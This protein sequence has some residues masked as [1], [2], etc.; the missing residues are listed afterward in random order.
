MASLAEKQRFDSTV[1]PALASDDDRVGRLVRVAV[2]SDDVGDFLRH[3]WSTLNRPI[4]VVDQHGSP[5]ACAPTTECGY[6]ALTVGR[7]LTPSAPDPVPAGWCVLALKSGTELRGFFVVRGDPILN[8]REQGLVGVACSLLADQLCRRALNAGLIEERR[9]VLKRRLVADPRLTRERARAE[10]ARAQ[11]PIADHYWP[12][13]VCGRPA[14]MGAQLLTHIEGLLHRQAPEHVAIAYGK[15]TVIVLV[16]QDSAGA[17]N[18]VG[19]QFLVEQVI[20]SARAHLH[21]SSL[22]GVIGPESA[23]LTELALRVGDLRRLSRS[24]DRPPAATERHVISSTSFALH[25]LLEGV[26]RKRAMEFV[27]GQIG[28]LLVYDRTHGAH[29]A[30]ILE[31]ALDTHNREDAARAAYMHRNTFRRHFT[32]ANELVQRDLAEPGQRLAVHVALKLA[33][34]LGLR[35]APEEPSP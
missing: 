1:S 9:N 22:R 21:A 8:E 11:M 18:A 28:P 15:G 24:L 14:E 4:A 20:D 2:D 17:Q 31:I 12:A 16:A 26:D 6:T 10:S 27:S 35:A 34:T 7:G 23:P 3:L 30:D 25:R 13:I 5:V 33:K 29:L 32:H 19:V